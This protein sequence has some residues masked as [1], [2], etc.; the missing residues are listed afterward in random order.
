MTKPFTVVVPLEITDSNL[1][2]STVPENDH[3]VYSA[4]TTYQLGDRVILLAPYHKIYESIQADNIGNFP[5]TAVGSWLEV[6]PTNRFAAF[7]GTIGTETIASGSFEFVVTGSGLTAM[8]F[9][10]LN[11]HSVRIRAYSPTAGFYYDQTT[12]QEDFA[13]IQN[14]FDYFFAPVSPKD[15]LVITGIPPVDNSTYTI[16]VSAFDGSLADVSLGTFIIGKATELGFTNFGA[17]ASII[18]YSRKDTDQ[19]GRTTLLRRNFSK[20]MDVTLYIKNEAADQIAKLLT[21][22]RATPVLWVGSADN[23]NLLTIYG[24]YR[25]WSVDIVYTKNSLC[26]LQIEGLT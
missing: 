13:V 7:D 16:T 14:W 5:P 4:G 19:F 22:I 2:S 12:I 20:K 3:P 26:S 10:S 8:A 15:D 18:D 11:A 1:V 17:K 9:L 25:D 21:D 6:A 24:F 23:F